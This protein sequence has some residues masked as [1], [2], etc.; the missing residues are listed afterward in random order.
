MGFAVTSNTARTLLIERQGFWS[1]MDGYLISG[2]MARIFNVP[3]AAGILVQ[4]VAENS[5]ASRAG[6]RAG[7]YH[8]QIEGE[9]LLLGGDIILSAMGIAMGEEKSYDRIYQ[10]MSGLRSGEV[11]QVVVLREGQQK[12][13][14]VSVR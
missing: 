3:Q 12:T 13:L 1:G 6:L 14:N 8:A 5:P 2:D 4:R 11:V 9:E 7:I 10:L